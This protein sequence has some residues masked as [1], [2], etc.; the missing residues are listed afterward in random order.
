MKSFR[1]VRV[2]TASASMGLVKLGHPVPLS[3]LSIEVNRGWP[4]TTST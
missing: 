4:E 1:S 3:N 2:V